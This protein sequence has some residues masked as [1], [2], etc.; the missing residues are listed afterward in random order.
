MKTR[1]VKPGCA[2]VVGVVSALVLFW[3]FCRPVVALHYSASGS[4]PIGYFY[5]TDV[6]IS[7]RSLQPGESA[8]YYTDWQHKSDYWTS[9]SF[10]AENREEVEINGPFSRVDVCIGPGGKIERTETRHGFFAR[11]TAPSEPCEPP[12]SKR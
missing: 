6:Y 3:Y 10:P 12:T 4:A 9:I 2:A 7:K 5:D 8:K 11:F 1:C